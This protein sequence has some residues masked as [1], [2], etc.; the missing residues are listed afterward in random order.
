MRVPAMIRTSHGWS[1]LPRA[2]LIPISITADELHMLVRQLE[3]EAEEA[4]REGR[5]SAA[6]RLAARA[7][8]LRGTGQ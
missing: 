7:A 6:D 1:T 2:A 8:G 4:Q 3:R 5:F